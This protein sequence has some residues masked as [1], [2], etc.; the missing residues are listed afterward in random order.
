MA[1]ARVVTVMQTFH[2]RYRA[3]V[4]RAWYDVVEKTVR[5]EFD[6]HGALVWEEVTDESVAESEVDLEEEVIDLEETGRDFRH[7]E[8]VDDQAINDDEEEER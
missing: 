6:A 8:A 1:G 7:E 4:T 3:T 2:V 5:R